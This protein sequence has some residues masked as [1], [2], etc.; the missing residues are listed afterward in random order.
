[1]FFWRVLKGPLP[2]AGE[3]Q[4]RVVGP[5]ERPPHL[6]SP[7]ENRGE[8][9]MNATDWQQ[10]GVQRS[11][12]CPL[13][14]WKRERESIVQPRCQPELYKRQRKRERDLSTNASK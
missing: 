10:D 2:R 6:A 12:L 8:R 14:S 3:D 9:K 4:V 11:N 7:P 1:M 13:I 5:A